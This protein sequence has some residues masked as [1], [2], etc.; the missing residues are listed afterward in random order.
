MKAGRRNRVH[1]K[2]F[3]C[4]T[5]HLTSGETTSSWE[6]MSLDHRSLGSLAPSPVLPAPWGPKWKVRAGFTQDL[7]QLALLAHCFSFWKQVFLFYLEPLILHWPHL[8]FLVFILIIRFCSTVSTKLCS[9]QRLKSL[10]NPFILHKGIDDNGSPN[11]RIP[12]RLTS[13]SVRR[14]E[15]CG[16]VRKGHKNRVCGGEVRG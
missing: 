2:L 5:L 6:A 10:F 1:L 15:V 13:R 9:H 8:S 12:R 7:S 16:R 4:P 14:K 3:S 11:L